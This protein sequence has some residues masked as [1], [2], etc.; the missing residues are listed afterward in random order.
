MRH[1]WDKTGR[2]A[3]MV[4]LLLATTGCFSR[5][6]KDNTSAAMRAE[7]AEMA[8][9][10]RQCLQKYEDAP[11]KAKANCASYKE[12]LQELAAEGRREMIPDLLDRLSDR[13][14]F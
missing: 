6:S 4:L 10:Y 13:F 14:L 2:L 1:V 11:D 7:V 9:L 3:V 5:H 8:K 12:A